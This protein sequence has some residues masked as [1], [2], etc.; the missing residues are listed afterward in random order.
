MMKAFQALTTKEQEKWLK[1]A[2][3]RVLTSTA[4]N[5]AEY[6]L[7]VLKAVGMDEVTELAIKMFKNK[8]RRRGADVMAIIKAASPTAEQAP[9]VEKELTEQE[10]TIEEPT[11]EQEPTA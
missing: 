9:T 11:V 5:D 4:K 2:A 7:A 1:K 3:I 8:G 6:F 10:A